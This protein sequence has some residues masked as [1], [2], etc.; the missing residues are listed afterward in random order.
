MPASRALGAVTCLLISLLWASPGA[1]AA[2]SPEVV[3]KSRGLRKSG[4]LYILDGETEL[5]DKAAKVQPLYDQMTKS[6]GRLEAVFR[7][8]AEYDAM[9]VQYKL[10][11]ERLRNVQA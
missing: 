1:L 4:S 8:Q 2:D 6:H 7:A 3:L 5:L 9:D 10:L 11:T